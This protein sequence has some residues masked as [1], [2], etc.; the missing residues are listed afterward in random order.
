[1][2]TQRMFSTFML[3]ETT[4]KQIKILP[5]DLQL[6]FFWAISNYGIEGIEPD[7]TGMELAIWI[8]MR[9]LINAHRANNKDSLHW[10]WKGGISSENA[11]IR[12][13]A[14]YKDWR[15]SVFKR[16]KYICQICGQ[17]GGKLHAQHIKQFS[18]H[19]ELRFKVFNG[20]TLCC[21]CHKGFHKEY[22]K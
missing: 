13:S 1:M 21:N 18:K 9:D 7:F 11:I 12:N 19:P 6:K 3:S 5:E 4:L 15:K 17:E 20:V 14:E 8:S 16:D 10:N 22:G 2:S